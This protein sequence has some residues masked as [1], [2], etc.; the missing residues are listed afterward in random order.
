MEGADRGGP[1]YAAW[2]RI[3]IRSTTRFGRHDGMNQQITFKAPRCG[4][5]AGDPLRRVCVTSLMML[6]FGGWFMPSVLF[7]QLGL[8]RRSIK[9]E[10]DAS[11]E[12]QW[13]VAL[14][15]M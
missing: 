13:F 7:V 10:S 3:G 12:L 8:V 14:R 6:M 5:G 1:S 11:G 2:V 9:H 15:T 4:T